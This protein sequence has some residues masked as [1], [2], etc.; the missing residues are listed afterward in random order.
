[1][2]RAKRLSDAPSS[3]S[4]GKSPFQD[5][6]GQTPRPLQTVQSKFLDAV[7]K[8]AEQR[9]VELVVDLETPT[10][11]YGYIQKKDAFSTLYSFHFEFNS[12]AAV[13][14]LGTDKVNAATP[15]QRREVSFTTG[16]DLDGV[17]KEI[18]V[19][20][21]VAS[22]SM[23]R[24]LASLSGAESMTQEP[25]PR[26][27]SLDSIKT[28]SA[29]PSPAVLTARGNAAKVWGQD[30]KGTQ[31][32]PLAA[33]QRAS[34]W[35][36][37]LAIIAV[38]TVVLLLFLPLFSANGCPTNCGIV[39]CGVPPTCQKYG[40]YYTSISSHYFGIGAE[41]FPP[42]QGWASHQFLGSGQDVSG[43]R[44]YGFAIGSY[45]FVA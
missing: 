41:Y 24:W 1:M 36:R 43:D 40:S 33:Q 39:N 25:T 17:L 34:P 32:K 21:E 29:S 3:D 6:S 16:V 37:R 35:P 13:F 5:D 12:A 31:A 27:S 22:K 42:S 9:Y 45:Y 11:G 28:P 4:W 38:V 19:A 14:H 10:S 7:K 20:I 8:Y 18:R 15:E 30:E 23:S 26:V 2:A 44:V